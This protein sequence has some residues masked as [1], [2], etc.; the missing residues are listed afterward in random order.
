MSLPRGLPDAR[1]GE[2]PHPALMRTVYLG[3]SDFAATVLDRLAVSAHRPQLVVTRPD[4]RRGRGRKLAA[5]PVADTARLLGIEVLQPE[6][7][8]GEEARARIAGSGARGDRHLRV[9]RADQGAAALAS[10]S[11]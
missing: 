11:C 6:D 2:T 3:T 9:R 8:N 7:V 10:T 1:I 4:A 5:P